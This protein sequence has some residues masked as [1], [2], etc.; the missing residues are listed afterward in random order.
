VYKVLNRE[1][2]LNHQISDPSAS[3]CGVAFEVPCVDG[4]GRCPACIKSE[5]R[6][7][8]LTD[9]CRAAKERMWRFTLLLIF[10][11]I[12]FLSIGSRDSAVGIATGYGLDDR[13]VG[14]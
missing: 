13:G 12:I 1:G 5:S 8:P 3:S 2:R 10:I 7:E 11:L 4:L 14:V 9:I 6:P